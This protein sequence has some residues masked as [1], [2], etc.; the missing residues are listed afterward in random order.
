MSH[1]GREVGGEGGSA[2]EGQGDVEPLQL[3]FNFVANLKP[4]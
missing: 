3:P 2:R 4:L 1:S